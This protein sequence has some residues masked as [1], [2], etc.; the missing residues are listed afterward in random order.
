MIDLR[1]YLKICK[2]SSFFNNFLYQEI[3]EEIGIVYANEFN[4]KN[5]NA[6]NGRKK[7]VK[8]A[9]E[10]FNISISINE[11]KSLYRFKENLWNTNKIYLKMP[12]ETHM[13][14]KVLIEIVCNNDKLINKIIERCRY[15]NIKEKDCLF[16]RIFLDEYYNQLLLCKNADCFELDKRAQILCIKLENITSKIYRSE[17]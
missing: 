7:I 1:K 9:K 11:I 13:I 5:S 16:R 14:L 10:K 12:F 3:I 2:L 8:V 15:R 4:N 17:V 6:H